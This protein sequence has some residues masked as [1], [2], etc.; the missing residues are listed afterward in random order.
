MTVPEVK[1]AAATKAPVVPVPEVKPAAATETIS[2]LPV[3]KG[4]T[5]AMPTDIPA[6]TTPFAGIG[7]FGILQD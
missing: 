5:N 2:P 7:G 6:D 4:P 3:I 1:P